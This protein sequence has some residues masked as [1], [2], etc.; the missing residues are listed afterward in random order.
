MFVHAHYGNKYEIVY[1]CAFRPQ[2]CMKDRL[3]I[4][5]NIAPTS[6]RFS[7]IPTSSIEHL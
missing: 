5:G 7:E 6:I 1:C 4:I 3:E 2:T